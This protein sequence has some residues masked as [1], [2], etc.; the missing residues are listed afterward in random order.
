[1]PAQSDALA[2]VYAT[3][4]L[5]LADQAG[6]ED[7]ILEVADELEQ[8]VEL[9]RSGRNFG[10]FLSS[11]IVDAKQRGESIRRIFSDN[12]TDLTLRFLLVLNEKGRLGHLEPITVAYDRLVQ[13]RFGR[14]E[15]NVYTPAPL[16]EAQ[17]ESIR[18]RVRDALGREPVLHPY[19]DPMMIGGLKLRIG[20]QLIDGSVAGQLRRIRH[21][22]LTEGTNTLRDRINRI[23]EGGSTS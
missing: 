3:S 22:L 7:K 21:N 12:V 10:E 13:E 15:V 23:I 19:T 1:M 18:N 2:N 20:D 16:G 17:L 6:G 4:L 5:D 11:P 8:I 14:V 9:A